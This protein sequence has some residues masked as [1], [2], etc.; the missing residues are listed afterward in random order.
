MPV[1]PVQTQH[2]EFARSDA[3][4]TELGRSVALGCADAG[5]GGAVAM[6]ASAKLGLPASFADSDAGVGAVWVV[7]AGRGTHSVTVR[8]RVSAHA[9]ERFSGSLARLARWW[10]HAIALIREV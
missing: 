10:R 3:Q 2:N 9:A 1:V 4:V 6:N 8:S 5:I 7:S